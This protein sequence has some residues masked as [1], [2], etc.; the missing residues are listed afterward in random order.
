MV[1]IFSALAL[2]GPVDLHKRDDGD[3]TCVATDPQ[4]CVVDGV[5][6]QCSNVSPTPSTL[7]ARIFF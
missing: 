2:A 7:Y 4:L 6:H 1:L 5:T 3:G